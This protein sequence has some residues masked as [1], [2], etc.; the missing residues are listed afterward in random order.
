MSNNH[1]TVIGEPPCEQEPSSVE[2]AGNSRIVS[3][4]D[5]IEK[6]QLRDGDNS[7][8]DYP[9]LGSMDERSDQSMFQMLQVGRED[10]KRVLDRVVGGIAEKFYV[11]NHI[12]N[13]PTA[14][15]AHF[16][17]PNNDGDAEADDGLDEIEESQMVLDM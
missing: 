15:V 2:E 6:E 17:R 16:R 12:T 14:N 9:W 4:G 3:T 8:E 11:D 10:A 7:S 5:E 1:F 13:Q